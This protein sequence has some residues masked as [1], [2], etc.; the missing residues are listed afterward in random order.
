MRVGPY[1]VTARMGAGGM[2]ELYQARDT[3]L[4]RDVALKVLPDTFASD[5]DRLN[6]FRNEAHAI[7]ALN[8]AN[9]T[10]IYATGAPRPVSDD[11]FRSRSI[12]PSRGLRS[13]STH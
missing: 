2:G 7:S 5:A 3:R 6:R 11:V 13:L 8:H 1:E 9:I 10:T 4:N 12:R